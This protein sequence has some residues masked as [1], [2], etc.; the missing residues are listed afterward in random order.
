MNCKTDISAALPQNTDTIHM[1]LMTDEEL[2]A[3]LQKGYDDIEAGKVQNMWLIKRK[4]SLYSRLATTPPTENT[5]LSKSSAN[6]EI[7]GCFLP[8]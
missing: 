4:R 5:L 6:V 2:H 7:A 1:D 3:K 8:S